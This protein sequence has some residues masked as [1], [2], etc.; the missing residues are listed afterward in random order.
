MMPGETVKQG[1]LDPAALHTQ[2][3]AELLTKAGGVRV[4]LAQ[5]ETDLAAGAPS[6]HDGTINLVHYGAWL[7]RE[8]SNRGN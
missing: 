3:L 6:N 4:D 5:I 2:Q 7:A 8:M 1:Q